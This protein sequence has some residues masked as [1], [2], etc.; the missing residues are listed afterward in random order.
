MAKEKR[1]G[2]AIGDK[3]CLRENF[4]I[5]VIGDHHMEIQLI[6]SK[7]KLYITK[8]LS[9]LG[10]L[11]REFSWVTPRHPA[12]LDD[13][14]YCTGLY[15]LGDE[16]YQAHLK[17]EEEDDED[18]TSIV[19]EVNRAKEFAHGSLVMGVAIAIYAKYASSPNNGEED[20]EFFENTVD[21]EFDF[22]ANDVIVVVKDLG[23]FVEY[24][25]NL[26]HLTKM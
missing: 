7:H 14:F 24:P 1:T 4:K 21:A 18:L 11:V 6:H 25:I 23:S 8:Y 17:S 3:V 22:Y 26:N 12:I 2:I 10:S 9:S 20:I 15:K 16:Q 19:A 5:L 13:N